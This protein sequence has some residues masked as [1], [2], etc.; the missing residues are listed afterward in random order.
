MDG[1]Q[2]DKGRVDYLRLS[3]TDRC[4]L[5]CTYCM[6][7][8][9]VQTREHGEILSYEELAA[10]A[11]AA[12]GAGISK[13]RITGG[14]PLVRT[15]C[16]DFV[17]MISRTSGIHDISLTTNGLLLPRFAGDLAANGL[18]RVNISLDSLDADRF[19]RITRGGRLEDTLAG[20]DAAFSA[21]FS[22]I[23]INTLLLPGVE[24]ELDAFVALT[25]EYDVHVRFIEFMPLDRRIAG[26]EDLGGEGRLLPAGD[27]LRRLMQE[28][29]LV[30]HDGPYGHGP[31]QYWKVAGARGTIGF[32][33]GVSDHFCE[34]CNRLRLTADG[35][36]RTCLFSGRE[37][38]IR[39]LLGDADGLRAEIGKAVAGKTFDRCSEALA[40][41]RSMSQIGG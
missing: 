7:P 24:E 28:Y 25:R 5:R 21:G 39:P 23:K 41:E 20:I 6:P 8:D 27:V 14:E 34:T 2:R 36:L 35:R 40:N 29:V 13:V 33:A 19:A 15:G 16:A 9:G 17:G 37:V 12:A 22:P 1:S 10:F 3:I 11:R 18:H 26:D 32:I 38:N 4:N 30:G 31:A